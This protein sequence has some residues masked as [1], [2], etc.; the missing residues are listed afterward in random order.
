MLIRKGLGLA[1]AA[2]VTVSSLAACSGGNSGAG[3]E[4]AAGATAAPSV[5]KTGF[6][7]VNEPISLRFFTGKS[8]TNGNN[9]EETLVWSEYA[10]MTNMNVKFELVP[11]ENLTDKRNLVLASGEYPDAFYSARVSAAELYKY[12][13]QG[14]FVPLNDMIGEY[15]PNLKKVLDTYPFIK[16]GLTMPDGNIYSIPSIYDPE[17][18]SMLIGMPLWVKQEW[19]DKLGMKEPTT[20]DE[21]YQFLKAV[22]ET[23]L[24]GNGQQDEIPLSAVNIGEVIDQLKGSWGLGNRGL[25]HKLVD[26]DPQ[27]NQLRFTKTTPEYKELL[28]FIN[29]LY[30]EGLLDKEIFTIKDTALNAK[31]QAGVLAATIVPN[32]AA[33]MGQKGYIGLGTLEGP[34]GDKLYSHVKSPLVWVGAFAITSANKHPEATLR[35]IDYFYGDEG[36]KFYFMGLKDKTYI[37]NP[38]GSLE[39]VKEITDNPDGLTQDQASVKYFTWMGGSYPAF[40]K[41]AYFRGSESLPEALAS[42]EKVKNDAVKEIWTSFN[43][44]EEETGFMSSTG[45]DISSYISEMESK[46]INGSASFDEWDNYVAT[47]KKMGSD[48]YMKVYQA[49]YDRYKAE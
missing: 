5:N 25:S 18:L 7:I 6:P 16:K 8:T 29:K 30:T 26:V 11:F 34:H 43:F 35:W 48:E 31:G 3:G 45:A 39:Y 33:V 49:A 28:Q 19:L 24:N 37:E 13:K 41:Q 2:L 40:A 42:A 47:L 22:K 44:T 21:F 1:L 12:G 14:V 46:F 32:P 36:A 4:A 9:F 23:D 27:T 15:A 17:F 38:D 10:K 20:I